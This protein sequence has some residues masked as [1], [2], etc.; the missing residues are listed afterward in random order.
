MEIDKTTLE[1]LAIFNREEEYAVFHL[2][3]FSRT[4]GGSAELHKIFSA[5]LPDRDT[6]LSIQ[7]TVK[8][9][10]GQL[11]QW[12]E[13][14]TNGTIMVMDKFFEAGNEPI[15]GVQGKFSVVNNLYYRIINQGDYSLIR[16]SLAHFITFIQTFSRLTEQLRR[17]DTPVALSTLLA[18]ADTLLSKKKMEE[19]LQV[20]PGQRLNFQKVLYFGHAVKYQ[21]A[22][23]IE[24]LIHLYHRLDAW[25]AMAMAVKKFN[26]SFPEILPDDNPRLEIQGLYHP[27]LKN[28]VAYDVMLNKQSNFLFLTG[29]NMAGK[30]TFI[31]AI[32]VAVFLAH[33][34]MGVPAGGMKLTFFDGLLSNIQVQ[35]NIF[36]GESYFYNEVQRVKKTI[37]K[38]ND[39]RRWLILIDELF[40]GTNFQD[41]QNCSA[42][43]IEGLIKMRGSLFVLSTHLYE[44]AEGLKHYPNISFKYFETFVEDGI[45]RYTYQLREGISNDRLGFII[46]KREKVLDLLE[47]IKNSGSDSRD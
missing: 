8:F 28:P 32:G 29:A 10:V 41:A 37:L 15:P 26:F 3:N 21:L 33:I 5:P 6:I 34:G 39:G 12:P 44:I 14:I 11:E 1:D 17:P 16:Y 30:S 27:L 7:S 35:D 47:Q 9:M 18:R 22:K 24:E 42:I 2:L 38:I 31:K 19:L 4:I 45:P 13:E 46:L 25:Y 43:V 23:A 20:D 36:L 40:K